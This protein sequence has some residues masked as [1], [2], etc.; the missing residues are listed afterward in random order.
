MPMA[1]SAKYRHYFVAVLHTEGDSPDPSPNGQIRF[2]TGAS[3]WKISNKL[4]YYFG[5]AFRCI[6]NFVDRSYWARIDGIPVNRT[7]AI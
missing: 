1:P 5:S 7:L 4:F 3:S 6:L 2:A